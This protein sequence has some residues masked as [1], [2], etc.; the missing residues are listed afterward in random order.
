MKEITIG[1]RYV[2]VEDEYIA[3]GIVIDIK[4]D[5]QQQNVIIQWYNHIREGL[6]PSFRPIITYHIDMFMNEPRIQMDKE[7]YR[8]MKLKELGI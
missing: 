2:W 6:S 1:A 5:K 3:N 4:G 7:Y 8:D